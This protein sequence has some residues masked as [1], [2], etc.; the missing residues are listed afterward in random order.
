MNKE[1]ILISLLR[2]FHL[3]P[4]ELEIAKEQV[5]LLQLTLKN[6]GCYDDDKN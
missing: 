5:R 3:E 1:Q 2:G 4:K 6:R